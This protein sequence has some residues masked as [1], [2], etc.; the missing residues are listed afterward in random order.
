[1]VGGKINSAGAGAEKYAIGIGGI[2]CKAADRATVRPDR[3]PGLREKPGAVD[4][5]AEESQEENRDEWISA[6]HFAIQRTSGGRN[7]FPQKCCRD[8]PKGDTPILPQQV[9]EGQAYCMA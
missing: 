7:I 9:T 1:M 5:D 6:P 3:L 2:E 4:T 8:Y